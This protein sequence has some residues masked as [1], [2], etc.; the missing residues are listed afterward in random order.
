MHCDNTIYNTSICRMIFHEHR[1]KSY[2]K[3]DLHRVER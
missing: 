3:S 1:I 2:T